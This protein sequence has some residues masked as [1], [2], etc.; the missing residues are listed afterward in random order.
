MVKGGFI[1]VD[2]LKLDKKRKELL[3]TPLSKLAITND[4]GDPDCETCEGSGC[5]DAGI[6]W[7]YSLEHCP[8]CYTNNNETKIYK[9]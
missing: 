8:D 4:L 2:K 5:V 3:D 9:L 1:C 7:G 6:L